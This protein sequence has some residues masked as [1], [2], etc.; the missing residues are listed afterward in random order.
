KSNNTDLE[1]KVLI[2]GVVRNKLNSNK[3]T[4][5]VIFEANSLLS[6]ISDKNGHYQ[7]EVPIKKN[8]LA[9]SFT[10]KSFSDT[11]VLLKPRSQKLNVSL[12]PLEYSSPLESSQSQPLTNLDPI[13]DHPWVQELV[14]KTMVERTAYTGFIQER[15]FQVSM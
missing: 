5:I 6:D 11:V 15:F 4:G 3:L 9:L 10:H 12:L 14:P 13:G 8:Q 2:E 1:G 7:L